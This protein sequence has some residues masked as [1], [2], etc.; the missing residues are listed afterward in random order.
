MTLTL[1]SSLKRNLSERRGGKAPSRRFLPMT[2]SYDLT[3][4]PRTQGLTVAGYKLAPLHLRINRSTSSGSTPPKMPHKGYSRF[5]QTSPSRVGRKV[6]AGENTNAPPESSSDEDEAA[7][8]VPS[9]FIKKSNSSTPTPKG[10]KAGTGGGRGTVNRHGTLSSRTAE[11]KISLSSSHGSS[12]EKRKNP[13]TQEDSVRG[14]GR[15]QG[16]NI[17]D[18]YGRVQSKKAR[19]SYKFGSQP[20]PAPPSAVWKK[21][22]SSPQG[23]SIFLIPGGYSYFM[24][25]PSVSENRAGL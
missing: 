23:S 12:T 7:T 9:L 17:V 8:I 18:V 24:G 22:G 13:A 21:S 19:K 20:R 6:Y 15:V 2:P 14:T 11:S 25:S 4:K 10:G 3:Y 16:K 5:A 1:D